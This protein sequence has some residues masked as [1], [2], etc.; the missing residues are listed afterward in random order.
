[1]GRL[2]FENRE[3]ITDD[4][5][6]HKGHSEDAQS[7]EQ[8]FLEGLPVMGHDRK[9]IVHESG[10]GQGECLAADHHI[11]PHHEHAEEHEQNADQCPGCFCN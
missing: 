7:A 3:Y 4:P 11:P 8:A 2:G 5:E 10:K 1:V 6:H 9:M